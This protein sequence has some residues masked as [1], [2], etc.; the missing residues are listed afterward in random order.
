MTSFVTFI[1]EFNDINL[2]SQELNVSKSAIKRWVT[3]NNVPKQY[4]IQ[5]LK[6]IDPVID[7]SKFSY[8]EKDQFFTSPETVAE[9]YELFKQIIKDKN[10]DITEYIFIEPSAGN[11]DFLKVL[12]ANTI[13][14]DIQQFNENVLVKDF[15]TFE[16]CID[17]KYIVFG[18]PPFGLR[19]HLALKFINKSY[20]F[21]DY[22]CFILPQLFESDGKGCCKKRVKYPTLLLSEKI[23][24]DFYLPDN[25]PVKINTVFQIWSKNPEHYVPQ[26]NTQENPDIVIYSLSDGGTPSS[27]RNKNML[28]KCDVYLPSTVFSA[29][30]MTFYL[31][32]E[33]LPYCRGYG[34]VFLKNKESYVAKIKETSWKT[35]AFLSTNSSYNLRKSQIL[36][37]LK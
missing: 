31:H 2:L 11:G 5:L 26:K 33:E 25:T 32:F 7:Y 37:V 13:A 30:D 12:P 3:N 29:D 8:K 9:C 14:M 23:N 16:P 20:E 28:N 24:T 27:T 6:F 34:L 36:K 22:V 1:K 4:Y 19:G 21:A 18:N 17:K 35:V 10:I 15:F